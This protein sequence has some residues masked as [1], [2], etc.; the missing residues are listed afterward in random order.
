MMH[1][2]RLFGCSDGTAEQYTGLLQVAIEGRTAPARTRCR[3]G[4]TRFWPR[5]AWAGCEG[6]GA[7]AGCEGRG[8][9]CWEG[10]TSG[11]VISDR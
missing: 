1:T 6:R 8:A 5:G 9:S 10:G 7:W 11:L 4:R 3:R 2:V